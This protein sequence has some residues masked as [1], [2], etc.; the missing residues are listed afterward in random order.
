MFTYSG[1]NYYWHHGTMCE[2]QRQVKLVFIELNQGQA[3]NV[4]TGADL[5]N[6]GIPKTDNQYGLS[7][8]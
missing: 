4:I 1:L 7:K 5:C 2:H 6:V 3:N 8:S